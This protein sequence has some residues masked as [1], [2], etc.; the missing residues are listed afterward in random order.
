M[1]RIVEEVF[2]VMGA[3]GYQT[4]WQ[5]PAGFLDVFYSKLVPDTAGHRS[6]MLQDIAAGKRT[7]IDALNGVV[8]KLAQRHGLA[9]P[10]NH[11]VCNLIQFIESGRSPATS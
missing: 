9:V 11:A 8:I 3:A 7:E 1:D 5:E 10:Y 4:H 6:S 2:A